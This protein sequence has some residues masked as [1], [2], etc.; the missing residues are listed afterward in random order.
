MVFTAPY[1]AS[2]VPAYVALEGK[3][4]SSKQSTLTQSI[5]CVGVGVHSG[6]PASLTLKPAPVGTGYL[7]IRTDVENGDN[8][9]PARYDTVVDTRM[10][11]KISNASGLTVS[12][13]EHVLAALA[14]AHITNAFIEI[15]GPEVPIMDGSSLV[16]SQ[17]IE[18]TGIAE[19]DCSV[20]T[21]KIL[22]PVKVTYGEASAE[23]IPGEGRLISMHFDGQGR[24]K[25]LVGSTDLSFDLDCDEFSDLL[26][27]ARTFGFYEDAEKLWAAGL[28]KGAS[29]DNTVVI[30][31]NAVMNQDGLRSPDEMIRHKV[32]DAVG[33]LALAGCSI[34]G[35]FRGVNSGHSLN[36]QLLR[37]L[38]STPDAWR[39][40]VE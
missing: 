17:M 38:F 15:N 29:L 22:K 18:S 34:I 36:N 32:L 6:K 12:T 31:D 9:I 27:D 11:T 3:N 20:P 5:S 4:L 40:I 25:D 7:F 28:A 2:D 23:F 13:V 8:V 35:H 19:Q 14:G 37:V 30:Q 16:F 33:D 39:W 24:L 26:S 10:C 21:L 1:N